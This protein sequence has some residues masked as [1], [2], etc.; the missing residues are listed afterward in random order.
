MNRFSA[1]YF[2]GVAAS[3]VQVLYKENTKLNGVTGIFLDDWRSQIEPR[4]T[5]QSGYLQL[6]ISAR[7]FERE[8]AAMLC[9]GK[10]RFG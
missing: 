4:T 6:T 5:R 9:N 3:I 2:E 10:I 1:S 8:H 7:R